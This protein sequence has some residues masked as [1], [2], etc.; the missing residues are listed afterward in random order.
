[1]TNQLRAVTLADI[2]SLSN[3]AIGFLAIYIISINPKLGA[4]LILLAAI[5]DGLDGVL[6][7]R[8]GS[9]KMGIYL[10]SLSDVI[11]FVAAPSFLLTT[12]NPA[13]LSSLS[14]LNITTT[15]TAILY[16]TLGILR[17]GFYT[18]EQTNQN[19][20]VGIPTTLSAT[21]LSI[22]Y[23]LEL[24]LLGFI[25]ITISL[26]LLMLSN[27]HYPDLKTRDALSMGVIQ[28]AALLYPSWKESVL[29]YLLLIVA[30]S[31]TLLSPWFYWNKPSHNIDR[32]IPTSDD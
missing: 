24:P 16:T 31:Y 21:L 25:V 2:A 28:L 14:L 3:A 15:G 10:D 23:L 22:F 29:L 17:L 7:R 30:I 13:S 8:Y 9:S 4:Q 26:S 5:A 18:A 19:Y 12:F 6:A 1:M 20:T 32:T 27:I 11:S